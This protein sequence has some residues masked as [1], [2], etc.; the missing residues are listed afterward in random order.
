MLHRAESHQR[1][2]QS[3]DYVLQG[4][5]LRD[6]PA[7]ADVRAVEVELRAAH[8][9]ERQRLLAMS[10]LPQLPAPCI[11]APPAAPAQIEFPDLDS[12]LQLK[13]LNGANGLT[14]QASATKL[15]TWLTP[16]LWLPRDARTSEH[17]SNGTAAPTA[18]VELAAGPGCAFW[19][20]GAVRR[21]RMTPALW[22]SSA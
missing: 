9:P 4:H 7:Y 21:Q 15:D 3:D 12:G 22:L 20:S 10:T 14:V 11:T 5:K 19:L 16:E 18:T 17:G 2:R 8:L 6:V 1:W 13:A